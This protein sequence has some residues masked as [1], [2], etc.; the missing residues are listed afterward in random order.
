MKKH[1][2]YLKNFGFEDEVTIVEPG[3]NGK[4]NEFQAAFGLLQLKEINQNIKKRKRITQLYRDSLSNISGIEFI[5]EKE[6]TLYNYSYFPIFIDARK[7]GMQRDE[8]YRKLKRSQY[9]CSAIFLSL[10]N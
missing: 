1:I 6:N 4:M 3:I 5:N 10:N 7:Y 9:L 2:D 8:L